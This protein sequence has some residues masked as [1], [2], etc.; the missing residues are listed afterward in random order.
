MRGSAAL[1]D[2]RHTHSFFN[3]AAGTL[4]PSHRYCL[5]APATLL[6]NLQSPLNHITF[7]LHFPLSGHLSSLLP[8]TSHCI[9]PLSPIPLSSCRLRATITAFSLRTALQAVLTSEIGIQQSAKPPQRYVC[10]LPSATASRA[11]YPSVTCTVA[12]DGPLSHVKPA[13]LLWQFVALISR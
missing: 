6:T 11:R 3:R 13:L 8:L 1:P 5:P 7:H 12:S 4:P 10:S 9:A 2:D